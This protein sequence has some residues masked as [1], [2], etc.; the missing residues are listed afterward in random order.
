MKAHPKPIPFRLPLKKRR[1]LS[2]CEYYSAKLG[3]EVILPARCFWLGLW[4]DWSTD[5]SAYV[6][7]PEDPVAPDRWV[8][9]FWV[10]Y[11]GT[12]YWIDVAD[13]ARAATAVSSSPWSLLADGFERLEDNRGCVTPRWLWARR[14]LLLNLEQAHPYAVVCHLQGGLKMTCRKLL[15]EWPDMGQTLGDASE[16]SGSTRF[17]A[18]CAIFHLVR[19][20]K[21]DL[22]WTHGLSLDTHLMKI[23]HAPQG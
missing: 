11:A 21:L 13:G 16:T 20:G 12:E 1:A 4:L 19:L 5:V 23:E 9:D 18:Q 15:Q 3:R 10:E 2:I 7:L 17:V 8:A 22:D 14:S 6:E